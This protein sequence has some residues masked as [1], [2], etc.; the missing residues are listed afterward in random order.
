MLVGAEGK[1]VDISALGGIDFR[2]FNNDVW[3]GKIDLA[4][5]NAKLQYA[6]VHMHECL[7]RMHT[8]RFNDSLH[9]LARH[10]TK[11]M[12]GEMKNA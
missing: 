2:E 8:K 3:N 4:N 5:N 1:S 11:A 6:W 9:I 10:K 7:R 12:N